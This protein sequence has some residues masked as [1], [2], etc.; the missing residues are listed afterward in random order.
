[1]SKVHVHY[2]HEYMY[3]LS[4]ERS[5]YIAALHG[6]LDLIKSAI[7]DGSVH[8]NAIHN[9]NICHIISSDLIDMNYSV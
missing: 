6:S 3:S 2:I 8:A 9:V 5:L 4:Q 7:E 1:M